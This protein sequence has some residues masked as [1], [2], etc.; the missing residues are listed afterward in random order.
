[1]S[2]EKQLDEL[3]AKAKKAPA[4]VSFEETKSEFMNSLSGLETNSFSLKLKAFFTLKNG[5][6]MISTISV[7]SIGIILL[8]SNPTND[9]PTKKSVKQ[10]EQSS[11][12]IE[13]HEVQKQDQATLVS[14]Q[15]NTNNTYPIHSLEVQ[16]LEQKMLRNNQLPKSLLPLRQAKSSVVLKPELRFPI[17][18]KEEIA[19]NHKQKKKMIKALAKFDKK[20]FSYVPSGSFD[21]Q[22]KTVSVQAFWIQ[23]AEVTN[24]EYR[25]FLFDLVIQNKRNEFFIACPD[26]SQW[27]E[28]LGESAM[29][30][31]EMYFSHEAYT[32]YPVV[33]ISRKGAEMYCKWLTEETNA[34]LKENDKINKVRIPTRV[35]WVK[36]A[37]SDGKS[38]PFPWGTVEVKNESD[39]YLANFKATVVPSEDKLS[40]TD[41]KDGAL[42]TAKTRTYTPNDYGL[43]NMSGNVAEMVNEME[44]KEND[45]KSNWTGYGTAGGSWMNSVEEIKINGPDP[46]PGVITAHPAIGF[47]VVVTHLSTQLLEKMGK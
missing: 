36:A 9:N 29:P 28:I 47:R 19:S 44:N 17:L 4:V 12:L 30:M 33:N 26:Q 1:M 7:L 46:Y 25:T 38:L 39:C 16:Q 27:L 22:E 32:D 15:L 18:T 42:Y 8:W 45:L 20:V 5:I 11:E 34:T 23:Q 31:Q 40:N 43:Y 21:Y 41:P 13:A 24:L 3:F 37:S 10:H 14:E 35:E 2:K 6:I